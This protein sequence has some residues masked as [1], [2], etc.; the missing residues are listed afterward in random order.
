MDEKTRMTQKKIKR[1]KI[2]M[3]VFCQISILNKSVWG[4]ADRI[5]KVFWSLTAEEWKIFPTIQAWL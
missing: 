3:L 1:T 4:G 5:W 2:S